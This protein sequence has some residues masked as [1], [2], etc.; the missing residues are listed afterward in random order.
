MNQRTLNLI[1]AAL[2]AI[3]AVLT[4]R[5]VGFSIGAIVQIGGAVAFALL[6]LRGTAPANR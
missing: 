4:V 5:E 6:A 1:A 3:A 2:F